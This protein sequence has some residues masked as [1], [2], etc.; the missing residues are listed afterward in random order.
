MDG[1]IQPERASEWYSSPPPLQSLCSS[2]FCPGTDFTQP[3]LFPVF[4][5]T[6]D[7]ME[8]TTVYLSA[9]H[10]QTVHEAATGNLFLHPQL[11]HFCCDWPSSLIPQNAQIHRPASGC[12]FLWVCVSH[13]HA[14]GVDL[15]LRRIHTSY[16]SVVHIPLGEFNPHSFPHVLG[17]LPL[18][19]RKPPLIL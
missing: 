15:H 1:R 3:S 10:K 16:L 11:W 6:I 2:D 9:H 5:A 4:W 8:F 7:E 18:S 13:H 12:C 14:L 17:A 19:C